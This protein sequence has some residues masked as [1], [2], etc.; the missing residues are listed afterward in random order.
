MNHDQQNNLN[1]GL[2]NLQTK[3]VNLIERNESYIGKLSHMEESY[4][5]AVTAPWG[6]GKTFFLRELLEK[7]LSE[8]SVFYYN[9]WQDDSSADPLAT[10]LKG[11]IFVT[12]QGQFVTKFAKAGVALIK[13]LNINVSLPL[14]LVE[15]GIDFGSLFP[16]NQNVDVLKKEFGT[17]L[18]KVI[19]SKKLVILVDELD[20]CNPAFAVRVLERV[21]HFLNVQNVIFI[22]AI[23]ETQLRE[24]VKHQYG[25]IDAVK[26]LQRFF[27]FKFKIPYQSPE[28]FASLIKYYCNGRKSN[29]IKTEQQI[30]LE[31]MLLHTDL[32]LLSCFDITARDVFR[33]CRSMD[34]ELVKYSIEQEPRKVEFVHEV[35][36]CWMIV[37]LYHVLYQC[38]PELYDYIMKGENWKGEEK[39]KK[40]VQLY[41]SEFLNKI[42]E[43][44]SSNSY[45]KE[46]IK[47]L[48]LD[49][50]I[51]II[52]M[53]KLKHIDKLPQEEKA[54]IDDIVKHFFE[55]VI[56]QGDGVIKTQEGE[57]KERLSR[58][59]S[60]KEEYIL[61]TYAFIL[62]SCISEDTVIA[63]PE[64]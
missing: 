4:S 5:I 21:K 38:Y 22:F 39:C 36:A 19:E 44:T 27:D 42:Y 57:V 48:N 56:T 7:R 34:V 23:D 1:N 46:W 47:G 13:S 11:I 17:A 6:S 53:Y 40:T 29:N 3:I 43:I 18:S 2:E 63:K 58:L 62:K 12:G 10:L 60:W 61:E 16:D 32:S 64:D 30:N 9:A 54:E 50:V 51:F 37:V 31:E 52:S 41:Y 33:I 20:R 35:G 25:N 49:A 24:T 55:K 28:F 26:Y 8:H 14:P 59:I 15:A 45:T